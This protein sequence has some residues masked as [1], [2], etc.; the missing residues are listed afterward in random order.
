M[1]HSRKG[2]LH[3]VGQTKTYLVYC[4]LY[5]LFVWCASTVSARQGKKHILVPEWQTGNQF[6]WANSWNA[7]YPKI[8]RKY[9]PL[10][11]TRPL[12]VWDGI[13]KLSQVSTKPCNEVWHQN[14]ASLFTI[15]KVKTRNLEGKNETEKPRNREFK[16]EN[17]RIQDR[18]SKASPKFKSISYKVLGNTKYIQT[19]I[20]KMMIIANYIYCARILSLAQVITRIGDA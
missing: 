5:C 3:Q 20:I 7:R 4:L 15:R 13:T 6:D 8:T 16:T 12:K 14:Q 11:K 17:P 1:H 19:N 2:F 10:H 9:L 18:E